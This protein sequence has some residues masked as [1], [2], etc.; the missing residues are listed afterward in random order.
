[1]QP[2]Q[3]PQRKRRTHG[4]RRGR[5]FRLCTLVLLLAAPLLSPPG[6][7]SGV[8][9]GQQHPAAGPHGRDDWDDWEEGWDEYFWHLER[10]QSEAIAAQEEAAREATREK[11]RGELAT[12]RESEQREREA[13]SDAVIA[14]SRASFRAPRGVYY[15]KPGFTS[16][17]APAAAAITLGGT[18][19]LYDRGI[20]WVPQG[21]QY[22]VVAAPFGAVVERIPE[23]SVPADSP[24]GALRYFMGTFFRRKDG[25]W[26]VARPPAG[27]AVTYLPDG[28]RTEQHQDLVRYRFGAILYRPVFLHGV[29]AYQVAA[30][31]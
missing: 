28:Y 17:E 3:R 20:F 15:R 16:D 10:M 25:A 13:Y 27:V 1:M 7:Q 5:A 11:R 29:L 21:T 12:K 18:T 24:Q 26:E 6:A 4:L 22:L 30:V 2:L 19:F 9:A 23:E 14:A 31:E 8:A